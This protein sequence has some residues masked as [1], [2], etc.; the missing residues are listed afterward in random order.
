MAV[1]DSSAPPSPAELPMT[2]MRPNR[3]TTPR[4]Q[5]R[6]VGLDRDVGPH[7]LRVTAEAFCVR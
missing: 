4:Y 7:E 2:S 6:H 3:S 1:L 5:R